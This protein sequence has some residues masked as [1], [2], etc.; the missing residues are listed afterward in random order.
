[1]ITATKSE[2]LIRIGVTVLVNTDLDYDKLKEL[3]DTASL[4]A[5]KFVHEAGFELQEE[6][7]ASSHDGHPTLVVDSVIS[8][9]TVTSL[10]GFPS[11]VTDLITSTNGTMLQAVLSTAISQTDSDSECRTTALIAKLQEIRSA[12]AI[13]E[14]NIQH[15]I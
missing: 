14:R 12:I 9:A 7:D 13:L 4:H 1:M 6:A 10:E 11:P 15:T 8:H 3:A 5:T 2:N